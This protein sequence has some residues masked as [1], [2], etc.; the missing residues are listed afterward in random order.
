MQAMTK[1]TTILFPPKLYKH[2]QKIARCYKRSVG[3]LVRNAVVIQYGEGGRAARL[4]AIDAL[5]R[6]NAPVGK[7]EEIEDQIER[8]AVAE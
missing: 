8:G 3:E 4:E 6:L 2:L 7:P 1:K 5:T